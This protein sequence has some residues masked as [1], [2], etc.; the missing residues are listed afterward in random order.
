MGGNDFVIENGT[1][2]QYN[3]FGNEAVIPYGVTRIARE[4]F[5]DAVGLRT[6]R[7]PETIT[8]IDDGAFDHCEKLG[9]VSVDQDIAALGPN[10]DWGGSMSMGATSLWQR[11][12]RNKQGDMESGWIY[13]LR[14]ETYPLQIRNQ[15]VCTKDGVFL[16]LL[17]QVEGDYTLP[18]GITQ[19]G[20]YA[21]RG[22]KEL[23]HVTIP[24]G[25][26]TIGKGA[27]LN[28]A[29]LSGV[30]LP[31]S[32]K[33][34]GKNVFCGCACLDDISIP[35]GVREMGDEV[36]CGCYALRQVTI[37]EGVA[38]LGSLPFRNCINLHEVILPRSIRKIGDFGSGMFGG[39]W[40]ESTLNEHNL[41]FYKTMPQGLCETEDRL[42]KSIAIQIDLLWNQQMSAR[43]WAGLYLFQSSPTFKDLCARYI[44][45]PYDDYV[46]GMAEILAEG[47]K[48]SKFQKAADF[49]AEHR[50]EL[51]SETIQGL[52]TVAQGRKAKKAAEQLAQLL[53]GET[54]CAPDDSYADL[55][56]AFRAADLMKAYKAHKGTAAALKA[57]KL[58]GAEESAP[59][60]LVLCAIVPYAEQYAYRPGYA[61]N[62]HDFQSTATV[63]LADQAAER[64]DRASLLTCL[65]ELKHRH[66][67]WVIPYCRYGRG[68][69]IAEV[70]AE[71]NRKVSGGAST[72]GFLLTARGALMLSDT[73]EAIL[74]LDKDEALHVYAR[75]HST[76]KET[77]RDRFLMEFGLDQAGRKTYDLGGR[78]VTVTM[79]PDLSLTLYDEAAGKVVK[80]LP[81]KN[82]DPERYEA[83]K[84]DLADLKKNLKKTV[85]SRC[86][87]LF[88]AFLRGKG[89]DA[90]EWKASYCTNPVLRQVASLLVWSQGKKTFTMMAQETVDAEGQPYAL[91]SRPIKV[92]HPMEM[93]P[94]DLARWQKYFTAHGLKQPFAQVWEP[95]I[96]FDRVQE[97]RYEGLKL[98][99]NYLRS[100]DKHGIRFSYDIR[101]SR[102]WT[103]FAGLD[104]E[105]DFT[106]FQRHGVDP[107]ARVVFGKL[108]V[109]KPGRAANHV[110]ALLDRWRVEGRILK[111]DAR[112]MV[113]Y[114]DFFTLAQVTEFLNL[115]IENHCTNCTAALLEYKNTHFTDF[116]PMD[117][118]TLE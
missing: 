93:D 100:R 76:T 18:D 53:Q 92:A 66:D 40:S 51:Q 59:E 71:M 64:L 101:S 85:K 112:M 39:P 48:P 68:A 46:A 87:Q 33:T 56:A 86:D 6:V 5:S 105:C 57:V 50:E 29:A 20:I 14:D 49:A 117:V 32:L 94:E 65:G 104:L 73:R 118:F 67:A 37:Q 13:E 25:V 96:D 41:N 19:I 3:G 17:S 26:V 78:Q 82:A 108:N 75:N 115:A 42:N 113:K 27:F 107:T 4:A 114:L 98:P 79:A 15:A 95:V 103:S 24:E 58:N 90:A 70:V 89:Q 12:I 84:T 63:Q 34:L 7:F 43:D 110:L 109:E 21:F 60:F 22:Q 30:T 106:K 54:E 69:E 23:T 16:R 80:S 38:D 35:S 1:L 52:L 11:Y 45:P 81:K 72:R 99:A 77:L 111:D 83:A 10:A 36:F 91:G 31:D 116:N 8:Q 55:R 9:C 97:D 74:K 62:W 2:K 88:E 102:L 61:D 47:G 44:T 28:C